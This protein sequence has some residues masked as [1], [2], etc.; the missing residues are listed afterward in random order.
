MEKK[1]IQGF[2]TPEGL[3]DYV[4]IDLLHWELA[5]LLQYI[6]IIIVI[7]SFC[8]TSETQVT[9]HIYF[10]CSFEL[11]YFLE[12][13]DFFFDLSQLYYWRIECIV[14]LFIWK[15][16]VYKQMRRSIV[17]GKESALGAIEGGE[18]VALIQSLI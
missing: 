4:V 17:W 12:Q 7:I 8:M 11:E 16:N 3:F 10:L 13:Q 2:L 18:S 15:H 5:N 14:Q 1:N 6:T 9:S